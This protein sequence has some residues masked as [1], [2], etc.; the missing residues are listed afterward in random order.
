MSSAPAI[1]VTN[2]TGYTWPV[3]GRQAAY[4]S[5]SGN[6]GIVVDGRAVSLNAEGRPSVWGTKKTA[7][8]IAAEMS[9]A[10]LVVAATV[11]VRRAS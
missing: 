9:V 3:D 1:Q 11:P 7:A 6:W 4:A 10:D 5:Q 2:L 8:Y